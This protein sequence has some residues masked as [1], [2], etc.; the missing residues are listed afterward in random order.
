MS[1][2]KHRVRSNVR[3]HGVDLEVEAMRSCVQ[4][5]VCNKYFRRSI[6]VAQ[7]V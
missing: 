6:P 5:N 3:W 4:C 7:P 1:A 2:T